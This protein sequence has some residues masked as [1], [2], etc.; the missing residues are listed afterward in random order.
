MIFVS[1]P[2]SLSDHGPED[3]STIGPETA[4]GNPDRDNGGIAAGRGRSE[5]HGGRQLVSLDLPYLVQ[6]EGK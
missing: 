4:A 3:A 2:Y 1:G 5:V 6:G